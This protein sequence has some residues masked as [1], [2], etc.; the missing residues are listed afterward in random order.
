MLLRWF[1]TSI[2][3]SIDMRFMLDEEKLPFL[4]WHPSGLTPWQIWCDRCVCVKQLA[5]WLVLFLG[6]VWCTRPIVL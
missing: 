6:L 1:Y 5:E 2:M 3:L 4:T